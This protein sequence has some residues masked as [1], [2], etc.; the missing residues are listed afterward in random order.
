MG[1][2]VKSKL[3]QLLSEHAKLP[4][5]IAELDDHSD[6]YAAGLKSFSV[7]QLMLAI[8]SEFDIEFPE[9][10]LNRRTFADMATI[11]AALRELM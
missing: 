7:V 5:D 6:L 3:R 4:V 8:E 1:E 9:R 2:A 10:M 11:E